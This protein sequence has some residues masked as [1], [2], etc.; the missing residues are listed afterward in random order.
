VLDVWRGY[1]QVAFASE[2]L[3]AV[4]LNAAVAG[5]SSSTPSIA[6]YPQ[7]LDRSWLTK[8]A[9]AAE[10]GPAH[11]ASDAVPPVPQDFTATL[12]LLQSQGGT[13]TTLI[14]DAYVSGSQGSVRMGGLYHVE[15]NGGES[16]IG[17]NMIL[18][19]AT[20]T[21][22]M[23]LNDPVSGNPKCI[24]TRQNDV[25]ETTAA[26]PGIP[27]GFSY[28]NT[29]LVRG[30]LSRS[31]GKT[32]FL[33][34]D[35]FSS[36]PVSIVE[37]FDMSDDIQVGLYGNVVGG[38]VPAHLVSPPEGMECQLGPSDVVVPGIYDIAERVIALA[39]VQV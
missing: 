6:D 17:V 10:S 28:L 16:T 14:G 22:T 33:F 8:L 26:P 24:V 2:M 25:N 5:L 12:L 9:S 3:C 7:L 4:L 1:R 11:T 21:N 31:P 27:L 32:S 13:N 38:A 37:L 39:R 30:Y 35:A 36:V 15:A 19:S 20:N 29:V 34:I 18:S 23:I